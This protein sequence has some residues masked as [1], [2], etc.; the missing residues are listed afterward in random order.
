MLVFILSPISVVIPIKNRG[1]LLP[2]LLKNLSNLNY[3]EYEI[4][5]VDDCSKDNTKAILENYSV[6]SITLER[7]VGSAEAR[8]IGIQEAKYDTIALTDSDCYVSQNWLKE[9]IPYL[10]KFDVVGGK[11]LLCDKAEMKLNPFNLKGK[12]VLDENT[13]INFLNTSNMLLKKEVWKKS[14][15]FLN[16]RIEDL[17]FSWRLIKKGYKLIYVPEGLVI[18]YGRRNPIRNIVRYL[19]YGKAYSEIASIHKMGVPFRPE[20][21]S[22]K[23]IIKNYTQLILYPFSLLFTLFACAFTISSVVLFLFLAIFSVSIFTYL[24]SRV[25]KK[26]DFN[27][28]F[29]K[30]CM[31]FNMVNFSIIYRL[32]K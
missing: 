4:I 24:I 26:I 18:H 31:L 16:Y 7:S 14:G 30:F 5:I 29:Y 13:S 25:V 2:N 3:P 11:V 32:K 19:K 23:E 9:L 6:K 17:E 8:N 1:N 22:N 21:L 27:Y 28:K 12:T 10:D 20:T 15:G